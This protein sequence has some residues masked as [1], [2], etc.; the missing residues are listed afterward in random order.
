MKKNTFRQGYAILMM[1]LFCVCWTIGLLTPSPASAVPSS[2]A[3]LVEKAGPG[4]VN[5]MS[6]KVVTSS[7]RKQM[8]YG[9]SDPFKDFLEQLLGDRVPREYR[10]GAIGSGFIIDKD[11][12]ILTNNHVV[13]GA[14][15]LKVKLADNK[16]Y[17]AVIVGQ[18]VKTDL[19]LIRIE[20]EQTFAELSLGD[21]EGLRVGDSVLAIGNP[22]GLGNTV[23]S[24]IVSAKYRQIGQGTYDNFIQTDASINPGNSGGPLIDMNGQVVGINS[25][26]FSQSGG[27]VGIGFAIPINLVK[28]ILPQL[29]QGKVMRS[30]LGVM[31]QDI[32]PELG[33]KLSLGTPTGA[34][35]SSIVANSPADKAGLQRGDVIVAFNGKA[36]LYSN[37]LPKLV[38]VV[39]IGNKVTLDVMRK[40]KKI[41]LE[42]TTEELS[43]EKPSIEK[44]TEGLQLGLVLQVVTPELAQRYGLS[45]ASGLLAVQVGEGSPAAEAGLAGGDIIVEADE[46]I[47]S[48]E[49]AFNRITAKHTQ[50]GTLLL[51]VDRGGSTIYITLEVP[52]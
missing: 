40:G 42:A 21:S 49:A 2:F 14:I 8:P 18:D 23:T 37:D 51:L 13:D 24:G 12:F 31:A 45:S 44:Q 10:Q 36:V 33:K 22:F 15:E 26:I 43:E 52:L 27:S 25:I 6:V 35:I 39:P 17:K 30:Y 28:D 20:P 7:P 34:L 9:S 4:V 41:Q 16:E 11:G 1:S 46:Q 19:A 5:I 29:R 32:T 47:V 3:D 48:D 38:A 50:G